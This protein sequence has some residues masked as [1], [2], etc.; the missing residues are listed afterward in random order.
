MKHAEATDKL[1]GMTES[2]RWTFADFPQP[3]DEGEILQVGQPGTELSDNS[4]H[5]ASDIIMT[6]NG[7]AE[8]FPASRRSRAFAAAGKQE[9]SWIK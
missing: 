3:S 8:I 2:H 6:S 9:V 4:C 5:T 1:T 7:L